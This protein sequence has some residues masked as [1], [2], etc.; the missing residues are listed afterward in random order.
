MTINRKILLRQI[1]WRIL[2]HW[3][4]KSVAFKWILAQNN[5]INEPVVLNAQ[6]EGA[7]ENIWT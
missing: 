6:P 3:C 2:G 5:I 7:G 4:D 1:T